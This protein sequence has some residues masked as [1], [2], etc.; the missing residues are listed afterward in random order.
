LRHAVEL[1]RQRAKKRQAD[2]ITRPELCKIVK[3]A[4]IA[5][6]GPENG[7]NCLC[8]ANYCFSQIQQFA[9]HYDQEQ[10]QGRVGRALPW[11]IADGEAVLGQHRLLMVAR[12]LERPW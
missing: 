10:E 2:T 4:R 6:N 12:W 1:F 5:S 11:I 7:D 8:V 3:W 9:T